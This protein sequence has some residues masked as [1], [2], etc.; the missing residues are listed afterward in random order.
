MSAEVATSEA[1]PVGARRS[2][3]A[4]RG[5]VQRVM[6][7]AARYTVFCVTQGDPCP[8]HPGDPNP[9]VD[10]NMFAEAP[11]VR[12][13]MQALG[14]VADASFADLGMSTSPLTAR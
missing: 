9:P 3:R 11:P 1:V 14:D 6:S 2:S 13:C 10:C 8:A 7:A 4:A 12:S 5:G